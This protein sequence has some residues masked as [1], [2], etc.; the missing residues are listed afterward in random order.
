MLK[1]LVI[2]DE[3]ATLT[4]F[5]LFLSAYGYDVLVAEDGKTGL[6]ILRKECPPIVFTDLKMP[7]MDGFEV[8]KQIKKTAPNTEVIVITGHGD[9]DLIVRALNLEATDFIN[10]P[11]KRTALDSALKRVEARLTRPETRAFGI[12]VRRPDAGVAVVRIQGT[13]SGD[14]KADLTRAVE[15]IAGNLPGTVIFDFDYN[16]TIQGTGIALLI[17]LLSDLK[18]RRQIVAIAGLSENLR[19]IFETVGVPR[20]AFLFDTANDAEAALCKENSA[21]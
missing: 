13:L 14:S 7:E 11:V 3:K 6:E 17:G 20:F 4:M 19:T 18:Q 5:R 9:M 8:L 12:D 2:D 15:A 16:T 10:K 1:V 21:V